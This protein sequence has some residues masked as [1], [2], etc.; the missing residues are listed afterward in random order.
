[1]SIISRGETFRVANTKLLVLPSDNCYG[2]SNCQHACV[3]K[4]MHPNCFICCKYLTPTRE[5]EYI[6]TTFK[7][8]G[9]KMPL[10]KK[11]QSNLAISQKHSCVYEYISSKYKAVVGCYTSNNQYTYFS[12][13]KQVQLV[14]H[15]NLARLQRVR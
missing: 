13:G 3:G 9:C 7:C 8:S 15:H 12:K 2:N 1:M 5:T 11:D 14:T 4:S 10:W 6:Q